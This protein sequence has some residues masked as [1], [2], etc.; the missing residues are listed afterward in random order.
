VLTV[1]YPAS[2]YRDAVAGVTR[3]GADGCRGGFFLFDSEKPTDSRM[4]DSACALVTVKD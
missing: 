1:R 4:T 3:S 2:R